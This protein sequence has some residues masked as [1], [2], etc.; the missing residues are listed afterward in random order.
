MFLPMINVQIDGNKALVFFYAPWCGHCK[1]LHPVWE[2]V[3]PAKYLSETLVQVA[4]TVK[5]A[6]IDVVIAKVD[7]TVAAVASTYQVIICAAPMLR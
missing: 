6:D 4:R 7:A 5:A 1:K 2:E 3:Q